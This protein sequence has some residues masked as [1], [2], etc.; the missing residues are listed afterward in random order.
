MDGS[1]YIKKRKDGRWECRVEIGRDGAKPLYRYFYGSTKAGVEAK[2]RTVQRNISYGID[3][4]PPN[5]SSWALRWYQHYDGEV[6]AT[7]YEGY[8]YTLNILIDYFGNKR[9]DDIRAVHVEEFL[10]AMARAGKSR[11]YTSKLRGML[12]QIMMSAEDNDLISKNPVRLAK[13]VRNNNIPKE[14][15]AF[16]AEEVRLLMKYL[17][18]NKIGIAIRVMIG[19]G[20][21]S[22]EM[23][24][25]S[26]NH[27][28]EDGS[29]IY[30]RQAVKV[31]KGS[32]RV[33]CT[34]SESG[35][36]D[37]PVPEEIQKYAENLRNAGNE[38]FIWTGKNSDTPINPSYFRKLFA[39]ALK[40]VPGVRILTPHSCRHTYVTM[41]AES[42]VGI[43]TIQELAGHSNIKMFLHYTHISK[44]TKENA[45][46]KIEKFFK[47]S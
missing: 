34:K 2:A 5:F 35:V 9:L 3:G 19:T 31:V 21:R 39:N 8:K 33:G 24:A 46:N 43:K 27:I 14:K 17:P 12:H 41:L 1:Y 45:V 26:P 37:I 38:N 42:G 30:V 40:T 47:C 15:E 22:Q 7:T 6:S 32:V 18:I 11:S 4:G 25:L 29:M 10:K 28:E 20:L 23:L 16:T 13:K 44:N 36:R